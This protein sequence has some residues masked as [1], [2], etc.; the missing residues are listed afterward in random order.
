MSIDIPVTIGSDRSATPNWVDK[1]GLLAG[2]SDYIHLANAPAEPALSGNRFKFTPSEQNPTANPETLRFL[3]D[4]ITSDDAGSWQQAKDFNALGTYQ[5]AVGDN[6]DAV[7]SLRMSV[8]IMHG[9]LTSRP[10]KREAD[11]DLMLALTNYATALTTTKVADAGPD[12]SAAAASILADRTAAASAFTEAALL[13]DKYL[14]P[15]ERS[16]LLRHKAL[17]EVALAGYN[18]SSTPAGKTE[19]RAQMLKAENDLYNAAQ[20]LQGDR[21]NSGIAAQALTYGDLAY[22]EMH[23]ADSTTD[24]DA[25]DSERH[26]KMAIDFWHHYDPTIA[27]PGK[28]ANA[29]EVGAAINAR[30]AALLADLSGLDALLLAEKRGKDAQALMPEIGRLLEAHPEF[31]IKPQ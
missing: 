24:T 11:Q 17:N 10:E 26:Y 5:W 6:E 31:R 14:P 1:H 9:Q 25:Q 18:N 29:Q 4:R 20:A 8:D 28:S 22:V 23:R 21:S 15:A 30:D 27:P 19:Y 7:S 3:Q 2:K 12:R 13:A 16:D